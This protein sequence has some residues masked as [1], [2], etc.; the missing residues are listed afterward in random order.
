MLDIELKATEPNAAPPS[1]VTWSGRLLVGGGLAASAIAHI[2]VGSAVLFAS[3][4]LFATVPEQAITV[5]IVSSKELDQAS[6]Q[7]AKPAADGVTP[8]TNSASEA[9]QSSADQATTPASTTPTQSWPQSPQSR[10]SAPTLDANMPAPDPHPVDT[11]ATT[12]AATDPAASI[13]PD[14]S[15]MVDLLHL[16]VQVADTASEAPPTETAA[17]LSA[18]EIAQFKG[19]LKK[20]WAP[21]LGAPENNQLRAV[22]RVVL[23]PDGRLKAKPALLA[24]SA[25]VYGPALVDSVMKALARCQPYT[26]LPAE[27]YE[28][29]K[30]L[31]LNFSQDD[32]SAVKPSSNTPGS[33]K[34]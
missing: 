1:L 24:A 28:E 15:T 9:L 13:V 26:T 21:S 25:S 30:V 7:P 22:V 14:P 11:A 31:D 16:P 17:K 27:K 20:C 12:P 6:D 4:R 18:A 5:D 8:D 29:W 2:A 33:P 32:I 19:Y 23:G 3:P 10:S 34:G